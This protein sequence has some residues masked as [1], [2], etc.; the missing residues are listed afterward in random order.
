M[1]TAFFSVKDSPYDVKLHLPWHP[2][3]SD[4]NN[5]QTKSLSTSIENTVS[6]LLN[7]SLMNRWAEFESSE[8]KDRCHFCWTKSCSNRLKLRIALVYICGYFF[9]V[10]PIEINR[11]LLHQSNQRKRVPYLTFC[12]RPPLQTNAHTSWREKHYAEYCEQCFTYYQ[13][14]SE[15]VKYTIRP[16]GVYLQLS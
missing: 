13:L 6:R 9:H 4:M 10:R 2:F 7:T 5:G 14:H 15:S 16:C 8:Q 12:T 11:W 1:R 3:L